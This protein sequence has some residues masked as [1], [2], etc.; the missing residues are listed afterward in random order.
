MADSDTQGLQWSGRLAGGVRADIARRLP[1]YM[2]DWSDGFRG[3]IKTVTAAL[4]MF[5]ACLAPGIA[6]GSFM[7]QHTDGQIGVVEYLI[8]QSLGG[9]VF[10]LISGQ[11]LIMLRP[12]GPIT[13]FLSQLY[14]I[15]GDMKLNYLAVQA[16]VGI[17]VGTY[18][19]IIAITDT[20]ALIRHV[21][22]FTQDLFGTFVCSI[23]ITLGISNI[24][25]KFNEKQHLYSTTHELI[26]TMSTLYL[27]LKLAA[28]DRSRFFNQTVRSAIASFAV[29]AAIITLTLVSKLLTVELEPLPVPEKFEP[30]LLGRSWMVNICPGDSCGSSVLLGALA[31]VPLVLLFFIDQ[32]VTTLMTEHS[33]NKLK[34]GSA[35]HYNFLLLGFFNILL[36]LLGCPYITGS[37][38]HSP[39]FARALAVTEVVREGGQE[40]TRIIKVFENRVDPLLV[41]VL[42]LIC[43]P[44]IWELRVMPTSVISDALFLFMGLT[45]LPGNDLFERLKLLFTE[46]SL[47][48]SLPYSEKEVPRSSM[49]IFT[50]V[51]VLFAGV[52]YAVSRSPIAVA[53]PVFLVLTI[54]VKLLIPKITGGVVTGEMVAILDCE[55]QPNC[56]IDEA[57][58]KSPETS[59]V[60]DGKV[61]PNGSTPDKNYLEAE[62]ETGGKLASL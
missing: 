50:I 18:M 3:G 52:L 57:T 38:P 24:L 48:P 53:F 43:L 12:T 25:E 39:Q 1:L 31:A 41:N 26:L 59:K 40:K 55:K 6:F 62:V 61:T 58:D 5:F 35:F 37:I 49:H 46:R 27:A 14:V 32:N 4:F 34:K 11:P 16:W 33:D 51:Q 29:P 22:K 10:A 2:S 15:C 17:F 13:V 60:K 19:V 47:Y 20:C 42:I 23:F 21:S 8:T 36:P 56:S 9:I 7:D 30:T 45:G 44:V 54:P 28:F